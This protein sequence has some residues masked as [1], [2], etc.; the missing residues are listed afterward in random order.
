MLT[1]FLAS[2]CAGI[3]D[4]T[5]CRHLP[6]FTHVPSRA[7][8]THLLTIM[9]LA[10]TQIADSDPKDYG[11]QHLFGARAVINSM[12]RDTSTSTTNDPV[13]RLCLGV[14]SG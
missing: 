9:L 8:Y 3:P 1:S 2:A 14:V 11:K 7:P 5:L 4:A 10:L 12:L 6:R 13:V